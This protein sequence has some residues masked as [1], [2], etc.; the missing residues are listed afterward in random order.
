MVPDFPDKSCTEKEF[1]LAIKELLTQHTILFH[2][3][4]DNLTNPRIDF[5]ITLYH[6]VKHFS[7]L[8]TIQHYKQGTSANVNRITESL[9]KKGSY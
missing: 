5:L 2:R 8:D 7:A 1:K 9:V 4:A 6:Q 3:E